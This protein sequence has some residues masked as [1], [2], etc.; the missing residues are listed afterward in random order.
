[1]P[2][3]KQRFSNKIRE[4]A[5]RRDAVAVLVRVLVLA[6]CFKNEREI[7]TFMTMLRFSYVAGLLVAGRR[8]AFVG[9]RRS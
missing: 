5:V 1:M 7:R 3:V 4:R 9:S 8:S 6:A 2:E